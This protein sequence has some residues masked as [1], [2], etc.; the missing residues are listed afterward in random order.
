MATIHVVGLGPGDISGLPLGTYQ[1]LQSGL[2]VILRTRIHPA[3]SELEA[4]GMT[5]ESFDA[6]YEQGE[7]FEEIYLQMARTLYE[8]ACNVG[9]LVYAVPGHPLIAEQS[10]QHLCQMATDEVEVRIGPGQSFIDAVSSRLRIDPIEGLILLDGTSLLAS[11]LQPSLHTLIAQVFQSAVASEVK[12]TLMDVYPDDYPITVIRA[13]GVAQLERVETVPLTEVDRL[14]WIDHL[15]TLYVAPDAS[16][17]A[18]ARDPWHLARLVETLRAPSGCPWDREQTHASLRAYVIEEAYEVADAIDRENPDALADELGDLLL[19]VLLHAQIASEFGD[20]SLRDVFAALSRKIIRRHP[21]VFSEGGQAD[22]GDGKSADEAKSA[23]DAVK[24]REQPDIENKSLLENVKRGAPAFERALK[25]QDVVATVGFDWAK[26]E[27]VLEK[28]KEEMNELEHEILRNRD[29]LA[30]MELGDLLF[31]C[32]NMARWFGANPETLL[33]QSVQKFMKRFA[34]VEH[35]VQQ[36]G[37]NWREFELS[38]LDSFWNQ[39][40]NL[41]ISES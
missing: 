33:S 17:E 9:D 10:V 15:T 8:Q 38:E 40:K 20:F 13:A 36:S 4:E 14:P 29:D 26:K 3:V 41:E 22:I 25:V 16:G 12:L 19:Q 5:F 23:W 35:F 30:Q 27:D 32:V 7:R 37:R 24:A 6:Y 18:Q 2:P 28:L 34:I 31:V 39:A 11:Q 21:H 1:L